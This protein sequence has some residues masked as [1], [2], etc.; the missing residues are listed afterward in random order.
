MPVRALHAGETARQGPVGI[1]RA[2]QLVQRGDAIAQPRQASLQ[3]RP[4]PGGQFGQAVE[5]FGPGF[6][7]AMFAGNGDGLEKGLQPAG[8]D[9]FPLEIGG[10][11]AAWLTAAWSA[12]AESGLDLTFVLV[13][14]HGWL[15]PTSEYE[16][17]QAF[18][19]SPGVSPSPDQ[20]GAETTSTGP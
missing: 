20:T 5:N 3:R 16:E 7:D 10:A 14:R 1:E 8:G 12:A 2:A 6:A 4:R 19:C 18:A 15:D 13:N 17:W 9:F 11:D